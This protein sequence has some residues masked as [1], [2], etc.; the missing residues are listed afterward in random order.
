MHQ[1]VGIHTTCIFE[2]V[3]STSI[4]LT[5]ENMLRQCC[6]VFDLDDTVRPKFQAGFPSPQSPRVLAREFAELRKSGYAIVAATGAS[7]Q[8]VL[9]TERQLGKFDVIAHSHCTTALIRSRRVSARLLLVPPAEVGALHRILPVL[10]RIKRRHSGIMTDRRTCCT[11]YFRCPVC[12]WAA[13]REAAAAVGVCDEL[14]FTFNPDDYG[15][16][17]MPASTSKEL[18]V[19]LVRDML[20]WEISGAA[21]DTKSDL[22]LLKAASQTAII[23]RGSVDAAADP[24]LVAALHTTNAHWQIASGA[25]G[26]GLAQALQ[27]ARQGILA[28]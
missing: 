10:Q 13:G 3:P 24:T 28:L 5:E 21:G 4:P 2:P 27:L 1:S 26:Y 17:V 22:P 7:L 12:F 16:S 18:L 14:R 9:A 20:G 8:S 19:K 25:H 23:A 6:C 11:M 15:I